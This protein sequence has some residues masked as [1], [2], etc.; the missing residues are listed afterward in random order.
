MQREKPE[1]FAAFPVEK[2]APSANAY[3]SSV[4]AFDRPGGIFS[5]PKVSRVKEPEPVALVENRS[6][7]AFFNTV[8]TSHTDIIIIGQNRKQVQQL[9]MKHLLRTENVEIVETDEIGDDGASLRPSVSLSRIFRI[10]VSEVVTGYGES[11]CSGEHSR[12]Q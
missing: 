10:G 9:A 11:L 8:V 12:C 4:P 3:V 1:P 7:F 6:V 2:P 5:Q